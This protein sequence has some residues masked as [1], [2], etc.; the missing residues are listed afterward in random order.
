MLTLLSD[1]NCEQDRPC[2]LALASY[3]NRVAIS[4]DRSIYGY[5]PEGCE[6]GLSLIRCMPTSS[7]AHKVW[8]K[9]LLP[10]TLPGG[11]RKAKGTFQA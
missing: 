6:L 8:S 10:V 9:T 1:L 7:L 2:S 5:G 11:P 4:I 3:R